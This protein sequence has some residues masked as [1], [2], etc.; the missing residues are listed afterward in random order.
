MAYIIT[1]IALALAGIFAL[2]VKVWTGFMYF[3]LTM[4]MLL[5]IFWGVWQIYKYFTEFKQLT[6]KKY[7]LFKAQTINANNLTIESYALQEKAYQKIFN[8]KILKDKIVHWLIV[9]F[10]FSIAI[11]F[12]VAMILL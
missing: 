7:A 12:L 10:C 4:L 1:M 6:E 11:S 8:K 5:A 3:V 9:L 2:L